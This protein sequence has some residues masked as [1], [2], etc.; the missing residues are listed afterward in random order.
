MGCCCTGRR[1]AGRRSSRRR[2][3]ASSGSSTGA[4]R[5]L[6]LC[7]A[8]RGN[9]RARSASSLLRRASTRR[10]SSSS[11]RSTR[12]RQ[13]ARR[14]SARWSGV[15]SRSSSP[16]WMTSPASAVA[17]TA[18]TM[19]VLWPGRKRQSSSSA[20]RTGL[21]RST[22]RCAVRDASTA[23]SRSV[24]PTRRRACASLRCSAGGCVFRAT[25]SSTCSPSAA[26]ASSALTL[27]PLQRGR[28]HCCQSH[29]RVPLRRS[30]RR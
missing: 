15:S 9:P 26:S 13:S 18:A 21:M 3:P 1:A 24:S 5:H 10:R 16:R 20:R 17:R 23:R 25:C 22:R 28:R 29:L 19:A 27:A 7:R 4:C 12:S 6:S 2:S 14:R 30:R 8:C 11:M